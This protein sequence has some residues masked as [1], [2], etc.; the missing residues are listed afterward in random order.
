MRLTFGMYL[1]GT[2]WSD[3]KASVGELQ[4]GPSGMLGLLATQ[5]GL[6]GLAVH[7]AERINQY[8]KRLQACD[9]KDMWFYDSFTADAWSTA[10]QMLAWRDE[11][12]DAGWEGQ[13]LDSRF[14]G[15]DMAD[16]NDM[17][18]RNDMNSVESGSARLRALAK[19]EQVNL[20]LA[21]G[22]EDRL[23]EVLR[24]LKQV[25][26]VAIERVRLQEAFELL[27]PVWQKIF[28]KLRSLGVKIERVEPVRH[29][30][31]SNNLASIQ[32]VITGKA[33]TAPISDND[34][35]L[36]LLKAADEWEAA[37]NLAL[38][39]AAEKD[40]NSGVTIVCGT[41]TDVLDQALSRHGLSQLG[42]SESSRWRATLQVLP[43][44][45]ANA[46]KPV[47][48][49]R[50]VELLSLSIA[51]VPIYAAR[52]LFRALREEPGVGGDAWK[53]A[54]EEIAVEYEQDALRKG[55]T[56][57]RKAAEVFVAKLDA[58]L[59]T[60]RWSPDSGI[61]EDK[62]KERCQWVID[63]LDW[64]ID[65]DPMFKDAVGHAQL[66]QKLS[67]GLGRIPRVTVE[68][69]LDS[70]IGM[71]SSTPDRFEQAAAWHVVSD[72]GQITKSAKTVI[73]WGFID[74]LAQTQSY[75]SEAERSSLRSFGLELEDPIIYR[76]REANAWKQGLLAAEDNLLLFYPGQING[77]VVYHHPFW[78]EI[79]NAAVKARPD[80]D[81]DA[82]IA[83]LTREE[84]ALYKE[85]LWRLAGRETLLRKVVKLEQAPLETTYAIPSD[86]VSQPAS[87]SYSQMSTMLSCP[88]RW[89]LQY[90]ARLRVADTL[91]VPTGNQMIGS[92]C[93]RVI[94]KL[95]EEPDRQWTP[96]EAKAKALELYDL[97][98]PSMASE[99]LL[100]GKELENTRTRA[101]IGQAVWRLVEVIGRLRL[102]VEKTEEKLVGDMGGVP[103]SGFA[104]LLLRDRKGHPFILDLKWSGSSS[105]KKN[106]INE[107]LAL[108][109][110]TYA[111]M[112]QRDASDSWA[113][114]GYFM[115][116]QGELLSDSNHLGDE[117][118]D[119]KCSLEETWEKGTRSWKQHFSA[120]K[121]GRLDANGLRE[122]A[123]QEEEKFS[124]RKVR[125]MLKSECEENGLLYQRPSCVFCDFQILCGIGGESA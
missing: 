24:E 41:D 36:I 105:Y 85:D 96:D 38:W 15:N 82:V 26:G 98:V 53:A 62:L 75:W 23:R 16:G 28:N 34:D 59:A 45:L 25:D 88:M 19:V 84:K 78:D 92:L 114:G 17:A 68:R 117:A 86:A 47:D 70:V 90:N 7:G 1:D 95:Y 120:V 58:F 44:V 55:K 112:M 99:L 81:E 67:A 4:L 123:L 8:M 93:H 21:L 64:R 103:F 76:R 87:L 101:A 49:N 57:A 13:P 111:W 107:G 63:W 43:L 30:P 119:S 102:V 54:L 10:K 116:A 32:T 110:A 72:P 100:D 33:E 31:R 60:D 29:E 51:P 52:R 9:G 94:E 12:I 125:T 71:G 48:I 89:A 122:I 61:P 104:D 56:G 18:G 124:D 109:L 115:L 69:M 40:A 20:P 11:L 37:Q 80:G 6:S 108:Q 121:G 66:M 97:L 39:L 2:R 118:L 65:D 42:C 22:D 79:H 77:E 5:L 113:H 46:W 91:S 74:P 73:W 83:C 3:K 106:E 35:S 27:P 14:R 50:L